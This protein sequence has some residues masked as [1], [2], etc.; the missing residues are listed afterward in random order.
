MPENSDTV[1]VKSLDDLTNALSR[2]RSQRGALH[3]MKCWVTGRD[4]TLEYQQLDRA[5]EAS[6]SS[7]TCLKDTRDTLSALLL[8]VEHKLE[9]FRSEALPAIQHRGLSQLPDEILGSIF[10]LCGDAE[11][12]HGKEEFCNVV[13]RVCRRF[14][15]IALNLPKLWTRVSNLHNPAEL[16]L[17][18][19][20]SGNRW[21]TVELSA[22]KGDDFEELRRSFLEI[23]L[24]HKVRWG[25]FK[26]LV[27][28]GLSGFLE[29]RKGFLINLG[30]ATTG[31]EVLSLT[32]LTIIDDYLP[33]DE[34]SLAEG[35]SRTIDF[36]RTWML[37][38][39]S[40]VYLR[41][42]VPETALWTQLTSDLR[43]KPTITTVQ[44][45]SEGTEGELN[46]LLRFLNTQ[47]N[48]QDLSVSLRDF[49]EREFNFEGNL[50][51]ANL[52]NLQSLSL[53]SHSAPI[54]RKICRA[55]TAPNVEQF[56]LHLDLSLARYNFDAE[57][58]LHMLLMYDLKSNSLKTLSLA[59]DTKQPI[60]TAS[61]AI[62][63]HCPHMDTA[64][65]EDF[66]SVFATR[67]AGSIEILRNSG[68]RDLEQSFLRDRSTFRLPEILE[69]IAFHLEFWRWRIRSEF[70]APR[71][72]TFLLQAP[73][74]YTLFQYADVVDFNDE[75]ERGARHASTSFIFLSP[76]SLCLF[77]LLAFPARYLRLLQRARASPR[78]A[79]NLCSSI[80]EAV[81]RAPSLPLR[82]FYTNSSIVV[83]NCPVR[84]GACWIV[85]GIY[86]CIRN[87]N[88][89]Y[90]RW[91]GRWIGNPGV[92]WPARLRHAM[93]LLCG[94]PLLHAPSVASSCRRCARAS[95]AGG[96]GCLPC[97][98]NRFCMMTE[99]PQC[100][101][102]GKARPMYMCGIIEISREASPCTAG[103]FW[104]QIPIPQE[105]EEDALLAMI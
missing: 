33:A 81:T 36:Y 28:L 38:S 25:E 21:L 48:L 6:Q 41:G 27:D 62:L 68:F 44:F 37:P 72:A 71:R 46:M 26:F 67:S 22:Y 60:Y 4:S 90:A 55:L 16:R 65:L 89:L 23:V 5:V 77:Q 45:T 50:F 31:L 104:S 63:L 96:R 82:Q 13:S 34:Y 66:A 9:A 94:R 79:S 14:H 54:A 15:T 35:D 32:T 59:V 10:E 101:I 3:G 57:Q 43:W 100:A 93:G 52:P 49:D 20:R 73:H 69:L 84:D 83:Q 51:K 2:L 91:S 17:R 47:P 8:D 40:S 86:A 80:F 85:N 1:S 97:R 99:Y 98:T 30:S 95:I 56:T 58:D 12:E 105:P 39:L 18:L 61:T 87:I 70:A 24:E 102:I 64:A 76:L 92:D 88:I 7:L 53:T 74:A 19:A 11:L 75:N 78:L 29:E 103:A 42:H